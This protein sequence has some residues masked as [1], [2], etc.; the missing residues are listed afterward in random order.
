M[1]LNFLQKNQ[2]LGSDF[3]SEQI[4]YCQFARVNASH[5]N[6]FGNPA[7]FKDGLNFDGRP[8]KI[9]GFCK[10]CFDKLYTLLK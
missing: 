2:V 8:L 10:Q 5:L 9:I 7:L 3:S 1:E 6:I 4:F